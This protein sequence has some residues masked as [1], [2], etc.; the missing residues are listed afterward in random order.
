M[1]IA[2]S[3]GSDLTFAKEIELQANLNESMRVQESF[4][5]DKSRQHWLSEGDRNSSFFH[6][7]CRVRKAQFSISCLKNGSQVL[8]DPPSIERH[9]L[10][11]YMDLF[12]NHG[13]C[14]DT[15]LVYRVIS[16]LVTDLDNDS[17]IALPSADEILSAVKDLD[18]TSAP[19]PDGFSG[20][21]FISCW[22]IVG[23][24]VVEAVQYFYRFGTL[25]DSFNSSFLILIPK[26]EHADSISQFRPIALSNFIFK[27]IP[28]ILSMR[29]A[30]IASRIISPHQHAFVP[31]RQI[32]NCILTTSDRVFQL[33][34]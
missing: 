30:S 34:R 17:L 13:D 3:G 24:D 26:V 25:P 10:D 23:K 27:V 7:M 2:N 15:N 29:L 8:G 21:F 14:E 31:G 9:I 19:G 4:L 1:S 20:C 6:A 28:K 33:V 18:A 5:R 32:S 12:S 22:D 11:Y 16:P